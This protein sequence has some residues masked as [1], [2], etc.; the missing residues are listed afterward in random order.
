MRKLSDTAKQLLIMVMKAE[1][2]QQIERTKDHPVWLYEQFTIDTAK[3]DL[4][5]E[6]KPNTAQQAEQARAAIDELFDEGLIIRVE[7]E[8]QEKKQQRFH[9]T[10]KGAAVSDKLPNLPRWKGRGGP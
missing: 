10:P 5:Y 6:E 8:S 3:G 7:S 2:G 1:Q 9:I 4:C